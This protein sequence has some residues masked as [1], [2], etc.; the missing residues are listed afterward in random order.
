MV[1]AEQLRLEKLEAYKILDTP[2]E[3]DFN[4]LVLLASKICRTPISLISLIDEKRQWFKAN[5][6]LTVNETA[7]EV[8]FCQHAIQQH[9]VF[10]IRDALND[11][12]FKY[13][14]LVTGYPDIR[15]YAGMPLATN[16]GFNLG[17]LCV[18]DT[19]PR[20]FK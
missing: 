12:R 13:N 7:R 14:P 16:D 15:F 5:I 8:S 2:S 6:G 11:E 20:D 1:A 10:L 18:I 3:S 17:T 9:E 4:E 19:V